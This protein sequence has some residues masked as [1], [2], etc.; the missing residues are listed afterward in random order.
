MR[1]RLAVELM[2]EDFVKGM[3]GADLLKFVREQAAR[4]MQCSS[5]V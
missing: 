1:A 4:V 5:D 2:R 3:Q